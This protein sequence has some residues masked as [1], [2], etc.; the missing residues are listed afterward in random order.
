MNAMDGV[1]MQ[2]VTTT[3]AVLAAI[4]LGSASTGALAAA[5]RLGVKLA[6]GLNLLTDVTAQLVYT[7]NFYYQNDNAKQRDAFGLLLTPKL[8]LLGDAGRY[9]YWLNTGVSIGGF[10]VATDQDDYIDRFASA[11]LNWD[12]SAMHHI[13]VN[14]GH[15]KDHDAFGSDRTELGNFA[16]SLAN[17]GLDEWTKNTGGVEYR[18]GTSGGTFG[19]KL[20]YSFLNKD[21]DTNRNVPLPSGAPVG[22]RFLD[23]DTQT[24]H[25]TG[26]YNYSGKTSF[27]AEWL[28]TDIHIP[29]DFVGFPSREAKQDVYRVG[30]IWK[31]TGKTSGDVRI[32][33]LDRKYDDS[34]RSDFSKVNWVAGVTWT[35]FSRTRF[36]VET[37][38]AAQDTFL[39]GSG[40]IDLRFYDVK[41]TYDWTPRFQHT[42]GY[43]HSKFSFT[44]TSRDDKVDEY[45]LLGNFLL[46]RYWKLQAGVRYQ[47]RSSSAPNRDYKRTYAYMGFKLER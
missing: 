43:N 30:A 3:T 2:R 36:R 45:S 31:A 34:A 7:D 27:V 40:F 5:D 21:Y 22:T 44:D 15:Q 12:L 42:L 11:G 23:Y 33:Y 46:S 4:L 9:Q 14:A 38:R 16:P 19:L 32:G 18:L 47:D 8:H 39:A 24:I 28:H 17:L 13:S 37:G 20:G 10:S 29:H 35:P 1:R 25:L 41:W 26:L 6:P